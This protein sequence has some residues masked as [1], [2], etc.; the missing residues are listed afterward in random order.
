MSIARCGILLGAFELTYVKN[1]E[2]LPTLN[3]IFF[4]NE[5]IPLAITSKRK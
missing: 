2:D 5:T 4:G 3:S 1:A